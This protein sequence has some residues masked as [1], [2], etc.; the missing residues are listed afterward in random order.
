MDRL[1][2]RWPGLGPITGIGEKVLKRHGF[3]RHLP[4]QVAAE[5]GIRP[6]PMHPADAC[7]HIPEMVAGLEWRLHRL[8][9][10]PVQVRLID[11]VR[12]TVILGSLLVVRW[13]SGQ[14]ATFGW[15][16]DP[17][18]DT[19][20]RMVRVPVDQVVLQG[21]PWQWLWLKRLMLGFEIELRAELVRLGQMTEADLIAR[22]QAFK[23]YLR[24]LM[25]VMRRRLAPMP[26]YRRMRQRIMDA[27][28][29]DP[30]ALSLSHRIADAPAHRGRHMTMVSSYNRAVAH[31]ELLGK[32][33]SETPRLLTFY[34]GMLEDEDFPLDGEPLQR[35][36]DQLHDHFDSHGPY[37]L[38]LKTSPRTFVLMRQ[39]IANLQHENYRDWL[40]LL[41]G[42]SPSKPIPSWLL[43]IL[44]SQFG[45]ERQRVHLYARRF[46]PRMSLWAFMVKH[47]VAVTES[48]E[49][50]LAGIGQVALWI[51][52]GPDDVLDRR[53]R[54]QGWAG[55]LERARAWLATEQ[56]D[57]DQTPLP[58]ASQI[59]P[60]HW[61][62]WTL[63]PLA[64]QH[65]LWEEGT[66]MGHCL[67]RDNG[68]KPGASTW[69]ASLQ[70]LGKRVLTCQFETTD[71]R[72]RLVT[73]MGR[74]NATPT[75]EEKQMLSQVLR[76]GVNAKVG[77]GLKRDGRSPESQVVVP[78][79][80][81]ANEAMVEPGAS[82]DLTPD[83]LEVRHA[84]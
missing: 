58:L 68:P 57:R 55:L 18:R 1:H 73:A 9:E 52:D 11:G 79:S 35:L 82:I 47:W 3:T 17:L 26:A 2:R 81:A 67:G 40:R 19:G 61:E 4:A 72:H 23:G 70:C 38:L 5:R 30:V 31:R 32:V 74:F 13:P 33:Q 75:P 27:L 7:F 44:V 63:V 46:W 53:Q 54:Q 76:H 69:F 20:M 37:R 64:T 12:V 34:A 60:R 10:H 25:Q 36:R 41:H 56:Q 43:R 6:L 15:D 24:D 8:I 51:V 65:A 78:K 48:A 77:P 14:L 28:D 71:G 84:A 29:L 50:D 16:G 21:I 45:N 80:A 39:F 83:F 22:P 59:R 49:G 62:E 42:L 66:H